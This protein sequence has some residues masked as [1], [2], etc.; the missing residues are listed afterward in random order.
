MPEQVEV[1]LYPGASRDVLV[2]VTRNGAPLDITAAT[3]TGDLRDS[4][5]TLIKTYDTANG[6]IVVTDAP[7]GKATVRVD[8]DDLPADGRYTVEVRLLEAG[9][10][11]PDTIVLVVVH[12][13]SVANPDVLA[14]RSWIGSSVP[15]TDAD[16]VAA[17]SRLGGVEEAAHEILRARLADLLASPARLDIDGDVSAD[18][19]K[20]IA[21]LSE[22]VRELSAVVAANAGPAPLVLGT[23]TRVD[24]DR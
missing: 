21:V 2:T 15:P 17:V 23:L 8:G 6:G 12:R 5:G 1:T 14:V 9:S 13:V 7:A 11:D 18:W 10:D 16:V 24:R 3:L 4:A 22:Q 19:T 20:N